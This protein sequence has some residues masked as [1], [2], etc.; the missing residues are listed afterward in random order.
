[1]IETLTTGWMVPISAVGLQVHDGTIH[2]AV[3]VSITKSISLLVDY[4]STMVPSTQQSLFLSDRNNDCWV[5]GT[6][7]DL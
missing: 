3:I 4:K 5:D 1:M 2:P 7:V 6:I